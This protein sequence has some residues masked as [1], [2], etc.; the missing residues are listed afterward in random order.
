MEPSDPLAS[1]ALATPKLNRT[2]FIN[3]VATAFELRMLIIRRFWYW[4][5]MGTLVFPLATFYFA[6]GIAPDD[7]DR[8]LRSLVGALLFSAA[9]MTANLLGQ[10]MLQDRFL[11]RLKLIITTP[12]SKAA[13]AL[14]TISFLATL[15]GASSGIVLGYGWLVGVDITLAWTIV[16]LLLGVMLTMS[17]LTLLVVSVSPNAEVGAL[18][19]NFAGV[20]LTMVSPVF[21]TMDQAPM[22]LRM[23]GYVSPMR[24]AADGLN[25]AMSGQTDIGVEF[26]VLAAFATAAL[27]VGVWKLKWRES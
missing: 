8:E 7:S 18:L 6:R 21:F 10:N 27:A 14:G 15:T 23:L 12:T 4:F 9:L 16:P 13:Y 26:A 24:Y 11:G 22:L 5:I 17:G 1:R 19:T 20:L 3:D 2:K 25:K